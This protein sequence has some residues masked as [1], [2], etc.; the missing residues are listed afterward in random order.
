MG[1]TCPLCALHLLLLPEM[2]WDGQHPAEWH[3]LQVSSHVAPAAGLYAGQEPIG[4][5]V[6]WTS[7]D[8]NESAC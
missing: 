2:L 4:C 6:W 5:A 1:L 8:N 3:H 7:K